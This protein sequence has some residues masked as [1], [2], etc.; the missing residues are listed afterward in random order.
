MNNNQK[1]NTK[2]LQSKVSKHSEYPPQKSETSEQTC[3]V[4]HS[5][6]HMMALLPTLRATRGTE[7]CK[8]DN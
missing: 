7:H 1:E 2:T 5:F 4:H 6:S 3:E 8:L